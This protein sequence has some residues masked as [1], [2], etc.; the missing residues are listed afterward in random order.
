MQKEEYMENKPDAWVLEEFDSNGN[1]VWYGVM[2]TRPSNLQWFRD[3]PAK[4]HNIKITPMYKD[5]NK[6]EVHTGV[7]SYK[8]S[9]QRMIEANG[10]L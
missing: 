3:L 5:S 6:T 7:T 8:E 1:I 2:L 10:G 9:T 4:K